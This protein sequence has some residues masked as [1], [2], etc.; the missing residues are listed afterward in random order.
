MAKN[1]RL[2]SIFFVISILLPLSQ[3]QALV[4][5]ILFPISG[6]AS[7]RNDFSEPRDGGARSHLGI[8]IIADKMTPVVAV[9]DGEIS[10]IAIPQASWG[11]AITITDNEGYS[12]RYLHLN[13]DTPGTD[14]GNGGV[15]NAYAQN[16]GRGTRV[17]KGQVLG[18]VGD[19]GNAESVGSHLHFEIMDPN[20]VHF[21]P[22][23][24]L[25]SATGNQNVVSNSVS[26]TIVHATE[27]TQKEEEQ[28]IAQRSLQEGMIDKDVIV[29]HTE[30]KALGY[31]SGALGDKYTSVTRE[32]IRKFQNNKKLIPTGIAD[33]ET[34]NALTVAVKILPAVTT[35]PKTSAT[36]LSTNSTLKI[37]A[38][39]TDVKK[40]QEKLTELKFF[41][42]D[43]T[44]YFGPITEKAVMAFQT[45]NNLDAVGFVGPKT[46]AL[47][48]APS[49]PAPSASY[50][51]TRNLQ[52]GSSGEDVKNLQ[53]H[54]INEGHLFA[55][56]TGFFGPLT[57][58]AVIA[59][60][61]ANGLDPVGIV[62]PKTREI[63]NSM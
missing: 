28:F 23:D 10:F 41:S 20:R 58:K 3:A 53:N 54:L 42:G 60:Q 15:A 25:M 11:Y 62:G 31:Y 63:L 2:L 61:N 17:T 18:W 1:S 55:E 40:L 7:F 44:G 14:D 13:N 21:N 30:L 33:A 22:Y 49:K 50:V 59:F 4:R 37:G 24:S 56:A 27:V 38:N 43:I 6:K 35:A 46:R 16:L 48:D 57:I 29:L 9:T 8:D 5:P 52:K 32:S 51:F 45:A 34:R 26:S 19:S 12:Y 36:I 39:G 47:L